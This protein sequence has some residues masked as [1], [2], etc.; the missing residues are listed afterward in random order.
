LFSHGITNLF[1][2][3][4]DG[5]PLTFDN[6]IWFDD[7]T[8]IFYNTTPTPRGGLWQYRYFWNTG[9]QTTRGGYL[10]HMY[11]RDGQPIFNASLP[12]ISITAGKFYEFLWKDASGN[13]VNVTNKDYFITNTFSIASVN[14]CPSS[15]FTIYEWNDTFMGVPP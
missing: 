1:E 15:F 9:S 7:F 2:D 5:I 13:K 3:D 14:G 12:D 4:N 8:G 6:G 10:I 11:I